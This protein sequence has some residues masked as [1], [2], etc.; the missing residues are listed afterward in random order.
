MWRRRRSSVPV[1]HHEV[2]LRPAP[3]V[4]RRCH[5]HYLQR[6]SIT[7]NNSSL[8]SSGHSPSYNHHPWVMT[9]RPHAWR[10]VDEDFLTVDESLPS[11]LT[12]ESTWQEE[13]H[14]MSFQHAVHKFASTLTIQPESST[15]TATANS[16]DASFVSA[17]SEGP[18]SSQLSN[19]PPVRHIVGFP[20]SSL[21][22]HSE[23]TIVFGAM[24]DVVGYGATGPSFTSS[25][26]KFHQSVNKRGD[27]QSVRS[28]EKVHS[29]SL[30]QSLAS[31]LSETKMRLA[32]AQA[33]RDELEFA[34]LMA[35]GTESSSRGSP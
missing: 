31:E 29:G 4:P 23:E 1:Q 32:L 25:N 12:N 20:H 2:T 13:A 14:W 10:E 30:I 17:A 34:F 6:S 21:G 28:T 16:V 9:P 3:V 24:D 22:H 5:H 26:L 8:S 19:E 18:S 11:V 15:T 7:S 35:T 27:N 33:E